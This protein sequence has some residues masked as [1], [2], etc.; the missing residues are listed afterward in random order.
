MIYIAIAD[1]KGTVLHSVDHA[2]ASN[3]ASGV[4]AWTVTKVESAKATGIAKL[5]TACMKDVAPSAAISSVR[6]AHDVVCDGCFP[7]Y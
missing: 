6:V 1:Q 4:K 2:V 7:G 5:Y 3:A